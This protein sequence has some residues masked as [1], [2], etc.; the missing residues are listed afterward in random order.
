[1][2]CDID[3][4]MLETEIQELR[5]ECYD[6]KAHAIVL[7]SYHLACEWVTASNTIATNTLRNKS[8]S[9]EEEFPQQTA[10]V[11]TRALINRTYNEAEPGSTLHQHVAHN[12]E[13]RRTS[14]AT[15]TVCSFCNT[16]AKLRSDRCPLKTA[17]VLRLR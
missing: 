3:G 4:V 9:Q 2:T 6:T 17:I 14:P 11:Q 10:A 5:L 8:S 12:T 16:V 13:R 7:L 1:M 15:K